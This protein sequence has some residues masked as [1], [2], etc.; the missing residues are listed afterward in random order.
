MDDAGD[1]EIR[2]RHSGGLLAGIQF[3]QGILDPVF[4]R[5]TVVRDFLDTL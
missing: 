1:L 5:V 2:F 4:A 3:F